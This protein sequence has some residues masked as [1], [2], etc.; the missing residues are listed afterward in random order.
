[1]AIS[2]VQRPPEKCSEAELDVFE[3]LVT[4]GGE[5]NPN[6]LRGR[7]RSA[8]ALAW[9]Q[10]TDGTLVGVG[11][12]KDWEL[13]I[14]IED[15]LQENPGYGYPRIA[16]ALQ[17]NKKRAARVMRLFG[18]KAYRRRGRKPRKSG[19]SK[20]FYPNLL[21]T[22]YPQYPHNIWAADFTYIPYQGKFI[23][24]ATVIDIFTRKIVG[25]DN[26]LSRPKNML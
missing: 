12:H 13:K 26:K 2:V 3:N 19:I 10:G 4:V 18:M 11:A 8:Y 23:Y 7:I 21:K 16:M 17:I 9:L 25:I 14:K 24:L 22:N 1:M 20:V 5:V 6:G 15:L